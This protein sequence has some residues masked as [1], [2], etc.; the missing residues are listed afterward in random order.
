MA[1]LL[2]ENRLSLTTI[3]ALLSIVSSFTLQHK[4]ENPHEV[5][6]YYLGEETGFAGLILGYFVD[7]VLSAVLAFAV[8]STGLWDVD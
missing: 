3:T 7:G 5:K 8:G 4:C 6:W 1:H 2:V